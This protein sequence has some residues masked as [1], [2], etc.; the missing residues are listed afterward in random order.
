MNQEFTVLIALIGVVEQCDTSTVDYTM[1]ALEA[2]EYKQRIQFNLSSSQPTH[3][4]DV[5][6]VRIYIT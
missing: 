4:S 6:P 3:T 2:L 1:G 5:H